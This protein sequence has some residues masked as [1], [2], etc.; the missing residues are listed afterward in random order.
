MDLSGII[1]IVNNAALLLALA[2][3]Y[4]TLS[5]SPRYDK[6]P[7]RQI[8]AGIVLGAVGIAI[9]LNPWNF[10]HGI[11]FDTRSVLLCIAG[12][13]FG[14][15]PVALAALMTAAMRIFIGGA[16]VWT[17]V[18]IIVGSGAI[19][20]AWRHLRR[21][22][23]KDPSIVELYLLGLVVHVV[24]L[25]CMLSLPWEIADEV[26]WQI[27]LPVM[28]IYPLTTAVL[29]NLMVHRGRRNQMEA[30]LRKSEEKFRN[31]F[32]HHAA[33][34]LLIDAETG[35]IAEAN[36]A[37]EKFYGWSAKE[38]RKRK[39]HDIN[40][41]PP[42]R[43]ASEMDSAR[44]QKRTHFEFRHRIA[45]GSIKNVD[46]Y[47][48]S[49]D[50]DGKEYLHSIINDA[51]DRKQAE[52]TLREREKF[53][54][55][56]LETTPDGFWAVDRKGVLTEVND[57]YCIMSGYGRDEIVG[58]SISELDALES[59]EE[60]ADH[61]QQIMSN[62]SEVF[63]TR[64]RRKDGSI[65]PV[66]ISATYLDE[67]GGKF[68]CFSRDLTLRKQQEEQVVLLGH[69]LD[70][71]PAAIMIHDLKGHLFYANEVAFALHGYESKAEFLALNLYEL[72]FS[73][74][75]KP[76]AA[77]FDGVAKKGENR[78]ETF[79]YR[80]DGSTFPLEIMAKSIEWD[81]KPAIL[82]IGSDITERKK[83][84]EA[85]AHSYDLMQYII[86]HANSAVAVHDRD[87]KYIYVSKR[88]LDEYKLKE[89]DIIG[90]HHYE[91]FPDLPQKWRDVHQKALKGEILRAERDPYPREDGTVEWTRWECRPWH[92]SDGSIG[93]FIVYTEVITDRVLTEEAL[94]ESEEYQRAIIEASPVAIIS[95]T[96]D[97][98][99]RSWNTAA[100]QRRFCQQIDDPQRSPASCW[101]FPAS[102]RS[103]PS[104]WMSTKPLRACSR[105]CAA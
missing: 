96:P 85:I 54:Q 20:L 16:G 25:V 100:E 13:F 42:D 70:A 69:M 61:L 76:V 9:M 82:N 90:K 48:S 89:R 52:D 86:E 65:F 64:H 53:L 6:S 43:I 101:H 83:A 56:I 91:V 4:D 44:T 51:T 26:L 14:T 49:I 37:V 72:I 94:R 29:G 31:L 32:Q 71:A 74:S 103:S 57:A 23:Q 97:G 40:T 33:A 60:T 5:L 1:G 80:K 92:E 67:H 30:A 58:M 12:F 22:R 77:Y 104:H 84:Q 45:D 36:Y 35:K 34:K 38:L 63:E 78:L 21:D 55:S 87:L 41:L 81:G 66:E 50:I 2:L 62:G 18:A 19:G 98:F 10:G 93:G 75:E 102:R 59:P 73:E 17:G 79:H 7:L 105:C 27:T 11:M 28:L 3:L 39:I 24:M 68:V 88:Y 15:V 99:V 47:S 46:V 8:A 95:L